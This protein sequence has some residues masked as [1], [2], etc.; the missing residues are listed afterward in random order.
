MYA[1]VCVCVVC[2]RKD[3][4]GSVSFFV[5]LLKQMDQNLESVSRTIY[6]HTLV[7]E[8]KCGTRETS[9][10]WTDTRPNQHGD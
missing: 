9:P 4:G 8:F 6:I 10:T 2:E 7:G 1:N 3:K 5:A